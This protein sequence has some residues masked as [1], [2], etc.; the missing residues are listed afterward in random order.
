MVDM[1]GINSK[2]M[3]I[4]MGEILKYSA[5]VGQKRIGYSVFYVD[6]SLLKPKSI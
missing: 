4:S 5:E 6:I 2:T 3:T 1:T